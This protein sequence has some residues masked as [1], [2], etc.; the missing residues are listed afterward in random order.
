[1]E[2]P[3][4]IVVTLLLSALGLSQWAM[5]HDVEVDGIY[6]NIDTSA[7]TAKVTYQGTSYA[8]SAATYYSGDVIIPSTINVDGTTY[9][10]T[11]IGERA[12]YNCSSVTSVTMPNSITSIENV[13]FQHCSQMTDVSFSEN[14][15]SIAD[16]SFGNCTKLVKIELPENLETIGGSAFR[17][18]SALKT[19]IT[20]SKIT[21]IN[22]MAFNGCSNLTTFVLNCTTPP[23]LKE[24]S[25]Y[26]NFVNNN[27]MIFVPGESIDAYRNANNWSRTATAFVD[28]SVFT[29]ENQLTYSASGITIDG[30]VYNLSGYSATLTNANKNCTI[31]NVVVPGIVTYDSKYFFVKNMQNSAFE[32]AKINTVIINSPY[33]ST[34]SNWAFGNSTTLKKV[35]LPYVTTLN[36]SAFRGS[37]AL[38]S[39]VAPSLATIEGQVFQDCKALSALVI[40]NTTPPTLR[41]YNTSYSGYRNFYENIMVF[42]PASARSTYANATTWKNY[43]HL[44]MDIAKYNETQADYSASS[45]TIDGL[46]YNLSSYAAELTTNKSYANDVHI[47]EYVEYSNGEDTYTFVVNKISNDCYTSGTF[48]KLTFANPTHIKNIRNWAFGYCEQVSN[49]VLPEGIIAIGSD[50]G[51]AFGYMH[52]LQKVTLP[53]SL[54]TIGS[55]TFYDDRNLTTIVFKGST[56]PNIG[57]EVFKNIPNNSITVIVPTTE[58]IEAYTTAL[59]NYASQIKDIIAASEVPTVEDGYYYIVNKDFSTDK[60]IYS[61]L[62]LTLKWNTLQSD[63]AKFVFH[64]T[65]QES[66]YYSIQNLYNEAYVGTVNNQSTAFPLTETL[67]TE[68]TFT[69]LSEGVWRIASS[70]YNIGYHT[71]GWE[72]GV[73]GNVIA[74][75]LTTEYGSLGTYPYSKWELRAVSDADLANIIAKRDAERSTGCLALVFIGN[76]ITQGVGVSN[77]TTEAAPIVTGRLI[78]TYSGK[79]VAIR[80]CGHSGSTTLDWMPGTTYYN[81]AI[82]AAEAI[83]RYGSPWF[84]IMLGTNDSAEDGPNGSPVSTDNYKANLKSIID[85]L[86]TKYEDAK[87]VINYPIWYSDNTHNGAVYKAEGLARLQSYHPIITTLVAEYQAAG[88]A[89]YAGSTKAYSYFEGNTSLYSAENGNSGTFYLHPNTQGATKLAQFWAGSILGHNIATATGT[90][91]ELSMNGSVDANTLKA[92]IEAA[93]NEATTAVDLSGLTLGSDVEAIDIEQEGNTLVY[94][95]STSSVTGKNIVVGTTCS[96]LVLTDGHSFAAPRGF[97][98][99]TASYNRI[100]SGEWG[101]VCL[102]FAVTSD[103][104]IEYY[105][106]T[107]ITGSDDNK[108]IVVEKVEGVL[109][110]GTP[111]LVR[112]VNGEGLAVSVSNVAVDGLI[113]DVSSTVNMIGSFTYDNKILKENHPNAY[114]IK[115]DKFYHIKNNFYC[116]AFRA[117]FEDASPNLSG[118]FSIIINDDLT[119]MKPTVTGDSTE[120]VAIYGADGTKR[121]AMQKGMNIVKLSNGETQKIMV[122]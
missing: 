114:Y 95:A 43:S 70:T 94:L 38:V 84:S 28:R 63:D 85:A 67:E 21:Y 121:A 113:K 24:Y 13:A 5:A 20:G 111:A 48:S 103:D 61:D 25:T 14:I 80:N 6:Y 10:V 40:D 122:N 39:V 36:G 78:E 109:A 29:D 53:A 96:N 120:I 34:I 105:T 87:V 92:A 27:I 98:A 11:A 79:N 18:C 58:D 51:I 33:L 15:T 74:W 57:S 91:I 30:L 104:N 8:S 119:A 49:I 107:G 90:A 16:W 62:G 2:K 81:E 115:N 12:F 118:A 52:A 31:T 22:N 1:M 117:Y 59:S 65:Q 56:P 100:M 102:P 112:K 3:L 89:V 54:Q 82:A 86:L 23:T 97:T 71:Q 32:G 50:G 4:K 101:T 106:I 45:V 72:G 66:G 108:A 69:R 88:K 37:T 17:S 19:V 55:Q 77:A 7:K 68:Q 41:E 110:A 64:I 35:V 60:A 46:K 47:P 26:Y 9:T 73:G 99:T 76:S 44:Y 75:E 93:T 116:D 42:V 83:K